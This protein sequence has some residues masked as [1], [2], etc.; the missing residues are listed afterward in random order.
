MIIRKVTMMA[1]EVV[2]DILCNICEGSCKSQDS[3]HLREFD[4]VILSGKWGSSS[5][6]GNHGMELESHICEGCYYRWIDPLFKVTAIKYDP[7]QPY[8]YD[9]A[10]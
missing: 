8:P 5:K 2:V 10:G 6:I 9:G 3:G 1:S 4:Y 7:R